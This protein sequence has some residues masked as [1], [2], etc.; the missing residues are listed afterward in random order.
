MVV[1]MYEFKLKREAFGRYYL[2][3]PRDEHIVR[4]AWG[5]LGA[6]KEMPVTIDS[7]GFPDAKINDMCVAFSFGTGIFCFTPGLDAGAQREPENADDYMYLKECF[8]PMVTTDAIRKTYSED[9]TAL[10]DVKALWG[11][12]WMGHA[13]PSFVDFAALGTDGMRE[14]IKAGREK[15]GDCEGFY[16]ALDIVMDA[17][18]ILGERFC[19]LAEE[20]SKQAEGKEKDRLIRLSRAM[21]H[22][23]KKPARD[24]FEAV[25]VFVMVFSFDGLDSPGHFD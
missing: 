14:K 9:E 10:V 8:L 2:S 17:I 7:A 5:L 3:A 24:F 1:Q 15:N 16:D 19:V 20:K 25:A 11:G 18:D 4:T 6:A 12:T 23:P 22:C 21:E 13:V